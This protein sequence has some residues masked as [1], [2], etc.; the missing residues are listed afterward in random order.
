MATTI[1]LTVTG[2]VTGRNGMAIPGV[3][4]KALWNGQTR[5]PE[6]VLGS[7]TTDAW[8]RYKLTYRYQTEKAMRSFSDK[9]PIRLSVTAGEE[10]IPVG[11]LAM[12]QTT[13][14]ADRDITLNYIHFTNVLSKK[15]M[16]VARTLAGMGREAFKKKALTSEQ[17][18]L[19]A[20]LP[21]YVGIRKDE[22]CTDVTYDALKAIIFHTGVV[23]DK[24]KKAKYFS[25]LR[26][27]GCSVQKEA[28]AMQIINGDTLKPL[29]DLREKRQIPLSNLIDEPGW[30]MLEEAVLA[31][32]LQ[33][34][35]KADIHQM[36]RR[37]AG[38]VLKEEKTADG[39]IG[40]Q[41]T[42]KGIQADKTTISK[43]QKQLGLKQTGLI[44]LQ[45]YR[46]IESVAM[47]HGNARTYLAAPQAKDLVVP[48]TNLSLN[49]KD[50]VQV[51]L[52]QRALAY[53]GYKI[54]K[55]EYDLFTFGKTTMEAVKNYQLGKFIPVTGK[56]DASTRK[57]LGQDL[58]VV[59]PGAL[60]PAYTH[61]IRGTVSSPSGMAVP[62]MVV[63]V[64]KQ[65]FDGTEKLLCT[66]TTDNEG[67]FC[68]PFSV[69]NNGK[70][71]AVL[72]VFNV[73][74]T[75]AHGWKPDEPVASKYVQVK[76]KVTFLNFNGVTS[77]GLL[78]GAAHVVGECNFAWVERCLRNALTDRNYESF[79]TCCSQTVNNV[80]NQA[81]LPADNVLL[82]VLAHRMCQ[83]FSELKSYWYDLHRGIIPS[84]VLTPEVYYGLLREKVFGSIDQ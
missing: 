4:I 64:Y 81:G 51:P 14:K 62:N 67:F 79:L 73:T 60:Q 6:D 39:K 29:N 24:K 75:I 77:E 66:R 34:A 12:E 56:F 69:S 45:T 76:S 32:R 33:G 30:T 74:V 58:L 7:A 3:T 31:K 59:N 22:G 38:F 11:E 57:E 54:D 25:M 23:F 17:K 83:P 20:R 53:L 1:Q 61:Q 41:K 37:A 50:E 40:A 16:S 48:N 47:S 36:V 46:R 70:I 52:L 35:G 21:K 84:D 10:G 82:F 44:D 78:T 28:A 8:G 42:R 27:L 2:K 49:M 13:V 43:L 55:R 15:E 63:K 72:A 80:A 9:V 65:E 26:E 5:Q 19:V 71:A 18:D 68:C